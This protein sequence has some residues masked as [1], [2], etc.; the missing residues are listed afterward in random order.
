MKKLIYITLSVFA[1]AALA[2]CDMSEYTVDDLGVAA[3]FKSE[4]NVE[5]LVN[6]FYNELPKAG[7]AYKG[8]TGDDYIAV[9]KVGGKYERI[10]TPLSGGVALSDFDK[11]RNY[12]YFLERIQDKNVCPLSDDIKANYIGMARFF[13]AI[14]YFEQV[15]RFGDIQW[16]DHVI[17]YSDKADQFKDR[18]NRTEVIGHVL[19]DLQ[20]AFENIYH[21]SADKTTPD[22]W[23]A[24]FYKMRVALFEASWQKYHNGNTAAAQP[25]YE[26]AIAACEEIMKNGGFGLAD[27]YR[28]LFTTESPAIPAKEVIMGV[29][30][31]GNAEIGW[32]RDSENQYFNYSSTT[33][34]STIRPFVN[35]Y[36]NADGSF[37]TSGSAYKTEEFKDEFT[38][39]DGRL[40]QTFRYPEYK[41][42]TTPTRAQGVVNLTVAPLGYQVIK[43]IM[44]K[45]LD[46]SG[47]DEQGSL[48][49]NY[50]PKYRYAEVLLDYA[51]A[52]A[53][54]GTLSNSD[55]ES[56]VGAL[57]RRAGITSGLSSKPTLVDTYLQ[58]NFYP[59]V[60]DPVILEIR[61]EKMV[62]FAFEGQRSDDLKRWNC[63]DRVVKADWSGMYI[64]ALET[65]YDINNDGV[66]DVYY[67][68]NPKSQAGEYQD[69]WFPVDGSRFG[70]TV[71]AEAPG[72]VLVYNSESE[73]RYWDDNHRDLV[74]ISDEVIDFYKKNGYTLTQNPGY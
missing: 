64:P 1:A 7:S 74:P 39:R 28:K 58:T 48:N 32:V 62:E 5:M 56:T 12:N 73:S 45:P 51:E 36:L 4:A 68:E 70:I 46:Q 69:I 40:T 15:Q 71:R 14:W 31:G 18:T 67:S 61:R 20:Y 29:A 59:T 57:R 41:F 13:R 55:W 27:N 65:P 49:M 34:F 25:Y 22:R 66:Y 54:L 38:G 43:W 2:S 17:G 53:E 11:V 44:D 30:M 16:Y 3:A 10:Y 6:N 60:T 35:I 26:M 24:L 50:I 9:D 21:T 52:K 33:P 72:Y 63:S 37:H 19:D 23:V 47:K 42:G 8:D